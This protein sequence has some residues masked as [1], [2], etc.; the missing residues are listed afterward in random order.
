MEWL[1]P[2]HP[3]PSKLFFVAVKHILVTGANGQLGRELQDLEA[4]YPQY[5]F[6]FVTRQQLPIDEEAAVNAYFDS[7]PVD[8]CINCAAYTAVDK[9]ESEQEKATAVNGYGTGYL[10]A[11]CYAR[12]ASFIHISTDYVF[13]G[14]GHQPYPVDYPVHPVN[15][16]GASK[17]LGEQ[18][19][20]Q[21]HPGSII[22]RTSWV[23]SVHGANF[24]KTMMRL[25][26][27]R[28]SL[29]VVEDQAGCPT[30]AA[31]LARA[32]LH[33]VP[34]L[35]VSQNTEAA[36]GSIYHYS[37]SGATNWY[38]FAKAIAENMNSTCEV[39]PIPS[40]Q[41]PTPAKR[42]AYSV[43]D[44]SKIVQQFGVSVPRWEESLQR[45]MNLLLNA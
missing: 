5:Q 28:P 34:Q 1:I 16:Y 20:V 7:N 35:P 30:Y 23:Y 19:A 17:L 42:P 44:C 29:N 2:F 22:I 24:V 33:I 8:C 10:A 31:D 12:N 40:S 26:N 13:D 38:L 11:A 41:Y 14:N 39:H 37:N 4:S 27:E 9:A 36:T 43:M 45:C 21:Q 25:M 6:Q 18:L 3:N 32:I 15:A